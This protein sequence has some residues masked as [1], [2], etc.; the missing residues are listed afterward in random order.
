MAQV[1]YSAAMHRRARRLLLDLD[2]RRPP[3][4]RSE[5]TDLTLAELLDESLG[6][7]ALIARLAP[8]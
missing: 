6:A 3:R 4:P 1:P 7:D 2:M 5:T 8:R